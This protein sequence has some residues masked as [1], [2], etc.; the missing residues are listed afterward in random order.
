MKR[1]E[2]RTFIQSGVDALSAAIA[3]NSGRISEFNSER[4]NEYPFVW[5]ESLSVTRTNSGVGAPTDEWAVALHIAKKDAAGSS[6]AEYEAI[7]DDCDEIARA[8]SEQYRATLADSLTVV[9]TQETRTPFIHKHADDTTGVIL[10]FTLQT[11]DNS[12]F[13]A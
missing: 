10:A 5:L 13:C 4:S 9:I 7:V 6:P 1:S 3:F 8:L 2:V 12:T 11:W